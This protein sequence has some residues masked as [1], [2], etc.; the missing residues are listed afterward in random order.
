LA[1]QSFPFGPVLDGP[2]G[3]L[4][5]YPAKRLSHGAGG[6]VP[7][8]IGMNLDE[9]LFL[10]R[11]SVSSLIPIIG[12][13]F[14]PRDFPTEDISIRLNANAT[15]SPAGPDALKSAVDEVIS[16]YPDDPGAG[17]P[18]GT[19]NE[20]FG[21]GPG[22]KRE[23]AICMSFTAC[24]HG[25]VSVLTDD[26]ELVGDV[27]FH[28][29]RRFW[30]QTIHGPKYAYLFTDPQSA[31]DPALGVYHSSELLYLFVDLSTNAPPNVAN[32]SRMM[33][34]Y[35]ISFA[36]SLTPNDGKGTKSTLRIAS[37]STFTPSD[38]AL[39]T[40]LGNV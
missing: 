27:H 12:T 36:V 4:R 10:R 30:T 28:A 37:T 34:D 23:A 7:L 21:T 17:S 26:C 38:L 19:G 32:L 11:R 8:L 16:L 18:F 9:G 3:I 22:Y 2:G 6:Q 24:L 1:I 29:Q 39:R 13:L 25:L 31:A 5:D 35:W 15:P 40:P 20:T 33:L 14:T